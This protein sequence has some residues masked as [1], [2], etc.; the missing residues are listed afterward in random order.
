MPHLAV[1]PYMFLLGGSSQYTALIHAALAFVGDDDHDVE[2][3]GEA[4]PGLD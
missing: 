3:E 4:C 2:G 1:R